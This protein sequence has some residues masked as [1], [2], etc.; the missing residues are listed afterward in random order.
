MSQFSTILEIL[1]LLEIL[2]PIGISIFSR[3]RI[4]SSDSNTRISSSTRNNS[5][6]F[7]LDLHWKPV[8]WICCYC[9]LHG[10]ITNVSQ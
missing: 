7:S 4:S 1:V 6:T 10:T 5:I 9:K 8:G 2:H 3:T